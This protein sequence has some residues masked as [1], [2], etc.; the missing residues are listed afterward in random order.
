MQMKNP[1]T[2]II[3]FSTTG[4]NTVVSAPSNVKD[5]VKVW[6]IFFTVTTASNITFQGVG[7]LS[8]VMNLQA[9]GS[10]F[11]QAN[12]AWPLFITDPGAAFVINQSGTSS[13]QGWILSSN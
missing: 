10:F 5:V 13:V 8:G 2:G 9:N 6:G 7:A 4:N 1:Q 3:N 11:W 12:Q